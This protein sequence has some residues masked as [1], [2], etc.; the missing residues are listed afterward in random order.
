MPKIEDDVVFPKLGKE[1]P[2]A[3]DRENLKVLSR[4]E[5]DHKLIEIGF[6][7]SRTKR[8]KKL[9]MNLPNKVMII[10]EATALADSN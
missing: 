5:A 9:S 10:W 4:L 6:S 2:R 3:P 8:W 1:S 7:L